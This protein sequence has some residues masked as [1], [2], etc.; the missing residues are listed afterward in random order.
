M[1]NKQFQSYAR[2]EIQIDFKIAVHYIT[3]TALMT[4]AV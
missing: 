2:Q 3:R 4:S 1:F